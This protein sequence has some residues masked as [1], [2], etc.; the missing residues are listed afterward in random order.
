MFEKIKGFLNRRKRLERENKELREYVGVLE[1][2]LN[3][4]KTKIEGMTAY[5]F[6]KTGL[7]GSNG[8]S[9]FDYEGL[10]LESRRAH[11]RAVT[12]WVESATWKSERDQIL[13]SLHEQH[14][15]TPETEASNLKIIKELI[16]FVEGVDERWRLI[17]A[18][19]RQESYNDKE[20]KN[21]ENENVVE[22][23]V[24]VPPVNLG[25]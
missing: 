12:G 13:R 5:Q 21:F 20:K 1:D 15:N 9:F 17:A 14:L 25:T 16:A 24:Y 19:L 4:M 3:T 7:F 6:I 8:V 18:E 10:E 22:Q 23:G 2:E 11:Q